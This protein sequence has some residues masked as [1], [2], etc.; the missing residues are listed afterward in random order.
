ME[1]QDINIEKINKTVSWFFKKFKN[2]QVSVKSVQEKRKREKKQINIRNKKVDR[3]TDVSQKLNVTT[4]EKDDEL[5]YI[6]S[7]LFIGKLEKF[8]SN[9]LKNLHEFLKFQTI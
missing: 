5:L 8:M 1:Q 6:F 9:A 2:Y 7:E 4:D 3:T